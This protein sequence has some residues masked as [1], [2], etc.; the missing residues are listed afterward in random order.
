MSITKN[1]FWLFKTWN[2]KQKQKFFSIQLFKFYFIYYTYTLSTKKYFSKR[3]C[4]TTKDIYARQCYNLK[5]AISSR[6]NPINARS[7]SLYA[8]TVWWY[9]QWST[10]ACV[11]VIWEFV[12]FPH[13]KLIANKSLTSN[14]HKYNPK[15]NQ[16]WNGKEKHSSHYYT[17]YVNAL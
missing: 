13:A 6:Q 3:I 8:K 5:N 1:Y 2:K 10:H 4:I 14:I 7:F 12:K 16:F 9:F 11:S 15:P 17:Q